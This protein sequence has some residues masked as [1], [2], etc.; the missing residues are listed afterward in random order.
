MHPPTIQDN[1][2]PGKKVFFSISNGDEIVAELFRDDGALLGGHGLGVGG[3]DD[4]LHLWRVL[5][6]IMRMVGMVRMVTKVTTTRGITFGGKLAK[7]D[8]PF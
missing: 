6:M 3:D 2:Q 8:L 4:G 5:R 7:E 1:I